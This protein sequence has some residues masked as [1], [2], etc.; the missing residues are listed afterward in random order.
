VIDM[1]AVV[2]QVAALDARRDSWEALGYEVMGEFGIPG[3]R[4]FRKDDPSGSRTHQVHAFA[5]GSREI[6]RHL[7]FRDYL[8]AHPPAVEAY[9]ALKRRL[10]QECAGDMR[11]YSEGKTDFIHDIESRV[12]EGKR[13]G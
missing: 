10:A 12:S 1:L 8:R 9:G 13:A 7:D 4:Y 2:P 6:T 11:C 3:R 5:G